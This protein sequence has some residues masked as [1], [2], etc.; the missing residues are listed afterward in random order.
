MYKL[1]TMY[2]VYVVSGLGV[3]VSQLVVV[4]V[5]SSSSILL[6]I[7]KAYSL[8]RQNVVHV[9]ILY[10]LR[11]TDAHSGRAPLRLSSSSM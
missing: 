8:T 11:N 4:V 7:Y 2:E 10:M 3:F 6:F 9:Y 5:V 1:Y